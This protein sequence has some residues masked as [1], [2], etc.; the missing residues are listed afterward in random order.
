MYIPR[1]GR[2]P[3]DPPPVIPVTDEIMWNR[4]LTD[5]FIA[6][7]PSDIA[8]VP[9]EKVQ[10]PTGGERRGALPPRPVQRVKMIYQGGSNTGNEQNTDGQ[11]LK[12]DYVIVGSWDSTIKRGDFWED[13]LNEGQFYVVEGIT[14]YNG[15][16]V[17]AGVKSY[18]GL[19]VYG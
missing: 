11:V 6:Q 7:D 15:Y 8:L 10:L 12:Y 17:K 9:V 14:P 18:G 13:P 2:T 19:P 16:E 1:S 4:D 5:W 3:L